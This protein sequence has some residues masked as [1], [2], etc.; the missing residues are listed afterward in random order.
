[1]G[2]SF[3]Q[4]LNLPQNSRIRRMRAKKQERIVKAYQRR[5]IREPLFPDLRQ[6][7]T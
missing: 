7:S 2:P 1:V 6:Q 3:Q 4:R 5:R